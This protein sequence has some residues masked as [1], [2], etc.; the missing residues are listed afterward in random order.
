MPAA[1]L[2]GKKPG[3][4]KLLR[5]SREGK[6]AQNREQKTLTWFR[7]YRQLLLLPHTGPGMDTHAARI[8]PETSIISLSYRYGTGGEITYY[9][10]NFEPYLDT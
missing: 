1:V 3:R 6:W 10:L 8:A 2:E 7:W 5:P 9:I 4:T